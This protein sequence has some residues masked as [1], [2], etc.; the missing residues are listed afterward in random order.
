MSRQLRKLI[1]LL[2]GC[3]LS[4]MICSQN[5]WQQSLNY[6]IDVTLNDAEH[7]LDGFIKIDYSNN[8]PDTL[9]YIWFHLWPNAY[10]NDKTLFSDQLLENGRTD[11]YFSNKEDRGYI[12]R[13]DFRVNNIR[14]KVE[15]HPQHIDIVKVNLPLY[16]YPGQTIT[17][18]TPFHVK[19]PFNFS[20]GGHDKQSYQ[21]TQW[22]PKPAVYDQKGWHPISYVDQGEF[23][24]EFGNYEVKITVPKQYVVAATGEMDDKEEM[25]WMTTRQLKNE[26]T[27]IENNKSAK[28]KLPATNEKPQ[29]TND[30]P[31]TKTLLF[32]QDNI[33]DFAWFADIDFIV[34]TDTLTLPSGKVIRAYSY[35]TNEQAEVWKNSLQFVKDATRFYSEQVGEYPYNVVSTV[36]GP[37]SFGGGME[38]P[39]ITIIS[40]EADERS[41]EGTIVHEV[42]HNWFYGILASNEREHPWMDEGINS[43]YDAEYERTKYPPQ[44][45]AEKKSL[46]AKL[47]SKE[48]KVFLATIEKAKLDQPIEW[49]AEKYSEINYGLI[50]YYKTSV[51]MDKLRKQLGQS[52]F[53]K[54]MKEYFTQWKFKHPYP[55]D[56]KASLE[57]ASG[58][59]LDNNFSE[60]KRTGSIFAPVKKQLKPTFLFNLAETDK[61]N[62]LSL[63]PALGYNSYDGLMLGGIVHNYNLPVPD[64]QFLAA[65]MYGTQSKKLTGL[66]RINYTLFPKGRFRK[67]DFFIAASSF[68]TSSQ[69]VDTFG[70]KE[71]LGFRKIVPGIRFTFKERNPRSEVRKYVQF[72]TYLINEDIVK[73]RL[74]SIHQPGVNQP[75]TTVFFSIPSK[76]KEDRYVNQ[77]LLV[78]ENARVLYP[79]RA[80]LKIEQG[81]DFVRAGFTGNYFFNYDGNKGGVDVRLFAGKFFYLGEKDLFKSFTTERYHLSLSAPKGDK[82]YTY[83]NYFI[84][85]NDYPFTVD[86]I[87]WT[88]P[89]QQVMQR[90]GF[91]KMNTDVQGN[92]AVSD[93]WIAALNFSFD[94][95]KKINPLQVLPVKIPLKVFLDLGT[96]ADTWKKNFSGDR[97]LYDAGLQLSLLSNTVNIYVPLFYSKV[98]RDYLDLY[99]PDKQFLRK[100]AFSIDI[101]NFNIKKI[102][103]QLPW[104]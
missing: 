40:P 28:T 60:L 41:L 4:I 62:Y 87:K 15:D 16:L 17:I 72:K 92:I 34:K 94:V 45:S 27:I 71:A 21:L 95:P 35:Y 49:N 85:R 33:H 64:L 65:P 46:Q 84:G 43:F 20:R 14:A 2:L 22:Y 86:G 38:Y 10:K 69:V 66:A 24:S 44:S 88:L 48:E 11:F 6:K 58:V 57:K 47:P 91:L 75:D 25:N 73:Y 51:W 30:K 104:L 13:L 56:I 52:L 26:K 97:F 1:L 70:N 37:K 78:I 55:D 23:Y 83:S 80:E 5:Y 102:S 59:N 99:V 54:S 53:E 103:R 61:Y 90:D 82:D 36:Q 18:T 29:T 3:H 19:L 8:S 98:Y 7:T 93:D 67:I 68:N 101:Q 12:N 63:A 79:Y 89:Y 42:G 31:E 9:S 50:V 39:T 96:Y 81:K 100:I 32:R 74:D 76:A 77:L